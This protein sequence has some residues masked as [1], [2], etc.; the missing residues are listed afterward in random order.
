MIFTTG[1]GTYASQPPSETP[2]SW[3]FSMPKAIQYFGDPI[4]TIRSNQLPAR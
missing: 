4:S 1:I 3:A 2:T